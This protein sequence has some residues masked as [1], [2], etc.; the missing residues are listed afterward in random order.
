M[1]NQAAFQR[2]FKRP[3]NRGT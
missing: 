2:M 1:Q 3:L